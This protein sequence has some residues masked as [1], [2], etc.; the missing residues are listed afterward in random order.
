MYTILGDY[1]NKEYKDDPE[2]KKM[3]QAVLDANKIISRK[4]L[5]SYLIYLVIMVALIAIAVFVLWNV[6]GLKD[7]FKMYDSILG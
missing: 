1:M 7:I 2:Y 6:L 4:K 3:V 5:I